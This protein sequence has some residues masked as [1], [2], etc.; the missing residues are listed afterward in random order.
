MKSSN[1]IL[2]LL[3]M[4]Q[5]SWAQD[6]AAKRAKMV[7]T[8]LKPHGITDK[9]TL[10]A[11]LKVKRHLFMPRSIRHSAYHD[12]ALP[13]DNGQTISQP[14]IVAFMTQALQL[15][16]S[17]RVL[18]IGTGS[19]YQ[20]AVLA[21]IVD[22]VYTIEIIEPL[23]LKARSTLK[24]LGYDNVTVKIGDGYIGWEDKAPFNAI[25]VTA[26]IDKIPPPLLD[27]LAEGG[28]LIIPVNTYG[29]SSELQLVS[30]N[31]GKLRKESILPVRFVPFTRSKNR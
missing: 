31:E 12:T 1:F 5:F 15:K 19:G 3:I 18:E 13:I 23:G 9:S 16:S 10:K 27:Q 2:V 21:E 29:N 25:I 11:M 17:D 4:V 8:Q 30:K 20:A 24:D 6:Y 14:Y 28:R 26:A 22:E 7:N